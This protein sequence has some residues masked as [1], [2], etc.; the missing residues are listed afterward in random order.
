MRFILPFMLLLAAGCGTVEPHR[1]PVDV[2]GRTIPFEATSVV[3]D[4]LG[5]GS[6][7]VVLIH[8]WSGDRTFWREQIPQLSRRYRVIVLDL[9]GHGESGKPVIDYSQNLF[10]HSVDAVLTD[11]GVDSPVVL[12]GHSMGTAV[13][14][15]FYRLF[16]DRTRGII[17]IDGS[18]RRFIDGAPADS[19]LAPLR[20]PDY[21]TH[22]SRMVDGMTAHSSQS[23][24]ESIRASMLRT[25]QHVLLSAGEGM[26]SDE[27][28]IED[29]IRV[30]LLSIL[31]RSQYW[32]EDYEHY[33]R[34]IAP[35][36]RMVIID[37]ADH[38]LMLSRAP[39]VN[40]TI[41]YFLSSI[42][43]L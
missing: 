27:I 29:E 33:V 32:D 15:Q 39:A 36:S 18:L 24:R 42:D 16:P 25:P 26:F 9:P 7:T 40:E 28:W 4:A 23:L 6:E 12:V 43:L 17:A 35:L 31:A 38:F 8:G 14:R 34:R 41:E 11:A 1:S 22:M 21:L 37:D 20:G 30:P 10:A 5:S 3:Y 19:F 2:L 13:A